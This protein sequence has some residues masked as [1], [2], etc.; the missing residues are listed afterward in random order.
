M[1]LIQAGGLEGPAL[2]TPDLRD[3]DHSTGLHPEVKN[4][5]LGDHHHEMLVVDLSMRS[6]TYRS[7]I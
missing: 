3:L 5:D 6:I 7:N 1:H 2:M 4:L